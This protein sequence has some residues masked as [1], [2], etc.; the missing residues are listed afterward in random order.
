MITA[1]VGHRGTGKT[2]LMKRMQLYLR[3]QADFVDLDTE[4]EKK[5]GKT[6]PELFLEHGEDYFRELERQ[7][8]LESLQKSH[9]DTY[10]VLGAGFDLSVVPDS[11]RVLWVKRRTDLDGRIFLDRPR[12]NPELSPLEEFHKRAKIREERYREHAD[13]VYLMAEGSFEN[14]HHALAVEKAILTHEIHD[15][16]GGFTILPQHLKSEKRWRLFVERY[17]NRGLDFFEVRDDLLS[18]E[19]IQRVFADMPQE[20][21]IFSFRRMQGAAQILQ[22]VSALNDQV[23]WFDWAWELGTPD[24]ILNQVPREKLILSLHGDYSEEWARYADK[25]GHLK[26][27][28]EVSTFTQVLQGFEWQ[29]KNSTARSFLPR[30]KTGQWEWCRRLL[31]GRQLINF[32]REDGGSAADQPPLW[33]WLMTPQQPQTFAAVLGDPA[34]HSFTPLEHSDF[35]HKKEMPVFAVRIA[36]EEWDEALPVLRKL[37]L[38]HAAVTAPHKEN[39]AKLCHHPHLRAV[40]TL[41]WDEKKSV[42]LGTSTDEQG[43]TE[44][45]EGAGMIAPLQKEIFVWGG[46]GTLEMIQKT[47]PHASYFSSRTGKPRP[48]SEDAIQLRPKIV[49]W[50]APRTAETLFPPL[51]WAP[52]MVF[53]LN[54][55]EDSMGREYAQKCGANYQS[56]VVM[57]VAQAQGQR[58]FWKQC[59][60]TP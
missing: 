29:Q 26:H 2:E 20:K 36:R 9:R 11:V 19:Q 31:K 3:D 14:R 16:H 41:Y 1:V 48:G 42:W 39:A 10:I 23:T 15:V 35:F 30:S 55:K 53:D 43:F 8:F 33:A 49:V 6:I 21:F 17:Q 54:Y 32:W 58:L 5:I 7:L 37:G 25:V 28:P 57:F 50:A 47:L 44:L 38:T 60:E 46:G 4:I 24:E 27:A 13:E 22:N 18:M 51:E 52:A 12:L 45:M 40:N 56:G 34:A 59:E